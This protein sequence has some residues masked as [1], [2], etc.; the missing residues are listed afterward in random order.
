MC[1]MQ[2]IANSARSLQDISDERVVPLD[3]LLVLIALFFVLV[4]DRVF[5]TVGSPLGKVSD[6]ARSLPLEKHHKL[7]A[8]MCCL[9]PFICARL[10]VQALLLWAQM[11]L[12]YTYC[13]NL[14]WS[15]YTSSSARTHLRL[16][17]LLKTCVFTL[18][19]LQLRNSYPP[20][21]SHRSVLSA[22]E[23]VISRSATACSAHTDLCRPSA[24]QPG[25]QTALPPVCAARWCLDHA[26]GGGAATP[27]SSRGTPTWRAGWGS[28]SSTLCPSSMSCGACWTGA[29]AQP[30]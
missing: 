1:S 3:Y 6:V 29:A 13:F 24:L 26:E 20:R 15:P 7:A 8:N 11:G 4:L 2:S 23:H 22:A 30:R 16:V 28:R 10:V 25:L 18:Y 21:A 14:F 5:Y 27:F 9:G 17:M 12:F 19:A